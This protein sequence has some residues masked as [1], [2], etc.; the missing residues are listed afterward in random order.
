MAVA[1]GGCQ[2]L[3]FKPGGELTTSSALGAKSLAPSLVTAAYQSQDADTADVYLSDIPSK[4][5]LDPKDTF[6][7]AVGTI[8]HIHLFLVP[9]AGETPIDSTACN[10]IVRQLVLAGPYRGPGASD[11]PVMGLYAGGGFL[12]PDGTV[13]S[14][15]IGGSIDA[16]SQRLSRS[17]SGFTDLLGAGSISGRFSAPADDALSHAMGAKLDSLLQRL[18][19][20][21]IEP[22][23]S[24]PVPTKKKPASK[25]AKPKEGDAKGE[26]A[27]KPAK[28]G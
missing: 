12:Y 19:A 11:T 25:D 5:F 18:P 15:P 16:A 28:G 1:L 26:S 4:R 21:V 3:Y 27:P 22:E 13:G 23:K 7:D 8:V 2:L 14:G 10:V 20:A 6:A 9:Q 24:T 17:T